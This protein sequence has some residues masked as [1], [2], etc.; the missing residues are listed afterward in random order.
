VLSLMS[1]SVLETLEK[2]V[3]TGVGLRNYSFSSNRCGVG[4]GVSVQ[5]LR[6]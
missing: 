2:E 1:I 6:V 5:V 3:F 4:V